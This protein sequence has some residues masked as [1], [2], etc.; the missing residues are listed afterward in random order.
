M[1]FVLCTAENFVL[2]AS[3]AMGNLTLDFVVFG[4]FVASL[5]FFI[6]RLHFIG[7]SYFMIALKLPGVRLKVRFSR[8]LADRAQSI[9]L[10]SVAAQRQQ[11]TTR[12]HR[13][14]FFLE[15]FRLN[16]L[17]RHRLCFCFSFCKL[18]DSEIFSKPI[19]LNT[20]TRS[21]LSWGQTKTETMKIFS[22][23]LFNFSIFITQWFLFSE[24]SKST[25]NFY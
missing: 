7:S 18:F 6:H 8:K 1:C 25:R 10:D 24:R 23:K 11:W 16:Y 22:E 2:N 4:I 17:F 3:A 9:F 21:K 20:S 12:K 13:L 14:A 5:T 19:A 15:D